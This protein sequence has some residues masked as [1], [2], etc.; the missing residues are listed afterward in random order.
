MIAS[1]SY[2]INESYLCK[3]FQSSDCGDNWVEI[4]DTKDFRYISKLFAKND[5]VYFIG[6]SGNKTYLGSTND[7]F[8]NHTAIDI[9]EL[10]HRILYDFHVFDNGLILLAYD[11]GLA[12]YKNGKFQRINLNKFGRNAT[13]VIRINEGNVFVN[14]G[15]Q[16]LISKDTCKTWQSYLNFKPKDCES[17][18]E[19]FHYQINSF[20]FM[21]NYLFLNIGNA[22]CFGIYYC[23]TSNVENLIKIESLNQSH[24]AKPQLVND[25]LFFLQLHEGKTGLYSLRENFQPYFYEPI[26]KNTNEPHFGYTC[27]IYCNDKYV[28]GTNNGIYLIYK[29]F[30]FRK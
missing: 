17:E 2:K 20:D 9:P 19:M 5:I 22:K 1:V 6:L 10:N 30:N 24:W 29:Q 13:T 11:N 3:I 16:V 14:N 18:K 12:L 7:M 26:K 21:N 23:D 25:K 8:L 28:L 27:L 15:N 4:F